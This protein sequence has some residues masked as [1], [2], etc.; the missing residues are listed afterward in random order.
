MHFQPVRPKIVLAVGPVRALGALESLLLLLRKM[1]FV[2]MN[3]VL[4]LGVEVTGASVEFALDFLVRV[5][6]A[7]VI[8]HPFFTRVHLTAV[9]TLEVHSLQ[10]WNF[11]EAIDVLLPIFL[12]VEIMETV[13][14]ALE[15]IWQLS[16]VFIL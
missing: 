11:V 3:L 4:G 10:C 6:P 7:D 5:A 16:F 2:Q 1:H 12:G 9:N 8:A 15:C 13:E 14:G